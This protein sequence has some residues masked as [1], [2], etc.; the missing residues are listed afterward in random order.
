MAEQMDDWEGALRPV[1]RGRATTSARRRRVLPSTPEPP[2]DAAQTLALL[3]A[4]GGLQA[5]LETLTD[6]TAGLEEQVRDLRTELREASARAATTLAEPRPR[7]VRS[8][9]VTR[10]P[11]SGAPVDRETGPIPT[12]P[13]PSP[14]AVPGS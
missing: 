7:P 12:R 3:A 11:L 5:T 6:R 9:R 1:G 8:A 14:Q 2:A 13:R 10:Q 4:I